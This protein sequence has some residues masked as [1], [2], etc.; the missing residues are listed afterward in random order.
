MQ[1]CAR[2]KPKTK[3][4]IFI[5]ILKWKWTQTI[6]VSDFWFL[7]PWQKTFTSIRNER[8]CGAN[9][10]HE[11]WI[12]LEVKN[13]F[14]RDVLLYLRSIWT[15][16]TVMDYRIGYSGKVTHVAS[17]PTTF[18]PKTQTSTELRV[19]YWKRLPR[20]S[21]YLCFW[22]ILTVLFHLNPRHLRFFGLTGTSERADGEIQKIKQLSHLKTTTAHLPKP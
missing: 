9:R 21:S 5:F 19:T 6:T 15:F 13:C 16:L 11:N 22:R 4:N 12:N 8:N 2:V 14:T 3:I 20:K 10:Q 18:P 1:A 7:H 17:S